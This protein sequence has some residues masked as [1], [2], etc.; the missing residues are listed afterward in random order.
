MIF[1]GHVE[2]LSTP[3]VAFLRLKDPVKLADLSEIS[4]A[5][6]FFFFVLAPLDHSK[7]EIE[8]LAKSVGTMLTDTV[9]FS[10]FFKSF[11]NFNFEIFFR[12]LHESLIVQ[13]VPKTYAME[14]T[15]ISA[16]AL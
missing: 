1:C 4:V 11:L 2:L 15:N 6:R 10:T 5:S 12:F 9:N 14:S 16:N 3:L 8:G 7:E 13:K